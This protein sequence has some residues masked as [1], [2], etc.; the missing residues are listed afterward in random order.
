[1]STREQPR[2]WRP[3]GT[4]TVRR[5]LTLGLVF[6]ITV[7]GLESTGTLAAWTD[8]VPVSGT[9]ISTASLAAPTNVAVT[10]ACVADPTPVRRPG[11]GG[12]STNTT[13]GAAT[14]SITIARPADAVA[15]DVLV[16]A[17]TWV[18]NHAPGFPQPTAPS[19]WTLAIGKGD[20]ALGQ[21]L[22]TRVVQPSEPADYTWTGQ[23][24][25]KV[26]A[27]VAYSGVDPVNPVNAA[28]AQVDM[29]KGRSTA[30]SIT[31][32]RANV[33]LVGVFGLLN[34]VTQPVPDG[35]TG[36]WSAITPATP[37]ITQR[38][39][40][41][42]WPTPSAT[43]ERV[44][45]APGARTVGSL[46]ALQ[47]PA[48]PYSTTTWTPSASAWATGQEFRRSSGGTVQVQLTLGASTATRTGGPLV[49]GTGYT[50]HVTATFQN[51]RSPTASA[52]FTA[53]GCWPP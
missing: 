12:V 40:D 13:A 3:P 4:E 21:Y 48:Y 31:T 1:M 2:R 7:L 6:G 47:P 18:G 17:I 10:Q 39:A 28:D 14:S 22:Y 30:P 41:Q 26:G 45:V 46:V 50:V 34:N 25:N 53:R 11:A 32:T 35:M 43:G 33:V 29:D 5:V 23:T 27:I 49:P 20:N 15:G 19:G 52:S 44:S 51:W 37:T 9:S 38:G 42:S 8:S 36:I 24:N 16:A